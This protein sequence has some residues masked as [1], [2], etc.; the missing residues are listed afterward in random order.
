M[1][2]HVPVS[3][4]MSSD[5]VISLLVGRNS[6]KEAKDVFIFSPI[7]ETVEEAVQVGPGEGCLGVEPRR[8]CL[9]V[10]AVSVGPGGQEAVQKSKEKTVHVGLKKVVQ[11]E[12][13]EGYSDWTRRSRFRRQGKFRVVGEGSLGRPGEGGSGRARKRKS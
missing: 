9:Q 10:E 4:P 2:D 7:F 13:G 12:P 11:V 6:E 3:V 1:Q 5:L 8:G